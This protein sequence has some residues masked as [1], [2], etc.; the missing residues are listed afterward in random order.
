M[1][2]SARTATSRSGPACS[3]SCDP[4]DRS[5]LGSRPVITTLA[6]ALRNSSAVARPMPLLPP[7]ISAIL[8]ARR[9]ATGAGAADGDSSDVAWAGLVVL[10]G[11]VVVQ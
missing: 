9:P 11:D 4:A 2:T 5:V 10:R 6:P 8:P 7:V 1:V 3:P